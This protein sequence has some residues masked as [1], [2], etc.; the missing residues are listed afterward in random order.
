MRRERFRKTS[1]LLMLVVPY[2]LY[3]AYAGG[4]WI[5]RFRFI[6]PVTPFIFILFA[7]GLGEL[8]PAVEQRARESLLA[9][10][11]ILVFLGFLFSF[12][13]RDTVSAHKF[14]MVRAGGAKES[15]VGLGNWLREHTAPGDAVALMDIGMVKYYSEREVVDISGLT[16]AHVARLPGGFLK[17]RFDIEYLFERNPKCVVLVS[18]NDIRNG[19]G[20]ASTYPIDK[21]IYD[22]PLFHERYRFVYNV[23]HLFLR[24]QPRTNNGY[25]MNVFERTGESN[26]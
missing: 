10:A 17:K 7:G 15:H 23:D 4:D 1:L 11:V 13:V 3:V 26:G 16:D 24:E 6:E 2:L 22:N 25:W 21:S 18:H 12:F 14:A 9:Q 5:P 19:G 8:Y 20:F